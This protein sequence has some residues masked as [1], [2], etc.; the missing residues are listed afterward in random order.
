MKMI[1]FFAAFLLSLNY[2]TAQTAPSIYKFKAFETAVNNNLYPNAEPQWYEVNFLVVVDIGR[3][4]VHTYAD[5]EKDI[6][7][8][9]TKPSYISADGSLVLEATGIDESG[10]KCQVVLKIFK[11]ASSDHRATLMIIY[12]DVTEFFRLKWD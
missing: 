7:L 3:Q 9:D 12:S 1:Y 5:Q 11:D 2:A 10:V 6:D 4:K 8:I